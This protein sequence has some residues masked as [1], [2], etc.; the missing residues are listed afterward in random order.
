M[1][2]VHVKRSGRR[3]HLWKL[4]RKGF[5]ELIIRHNWGLRGAYA[6]KFIGGREIM[7]RTVEETEGYTVVLLMIKDDFW[8]GITNDF[9][10]HN[11]AKRQADPS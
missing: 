1:L 10:R 11:A 4:R 9:E 6:S 7:M 5:R 8:A 3:P 2:D